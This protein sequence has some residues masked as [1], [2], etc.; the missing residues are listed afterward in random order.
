MSRLDSAEAAGKAR[1]YRL[2]D[3]KGVLVRAIEPQDAARLQAYFQALSAESRRNRFL[4][5]VNQVAPGVIARLT[6]VQRELLG[7][8]AFAGGRDGAMIGE[9][10]QVTAPGSARAEIALSVTDAWQRR[11]LGTLLMQ[12]IECQA[13]RRGTRHLFGD[14]LRTNTAMKGLA[15]K[16]GFAIVSPF[17]DARLIEIV[18]DL[19]LTPPSALCGEE[20]AGLWSIAA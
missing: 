18:K 14:V 10:V 16:A 3:G 2:P 9:T 6:G 7:F 17:T 19:A 20:F 13:R 15:R 11:G 12:H 5:A 1:V 4:G 8:A